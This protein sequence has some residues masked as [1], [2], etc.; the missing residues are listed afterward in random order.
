[1]SR[2]KEEWLKGLPNIGDIKAPRQGFSFRGMIGA[3][4]PI[5][6]TSGVF[7]YAILSIAYEMFYSRLGIDPAE[8]GL[9][10]AGIL[11][12]SVGFI[13][14]TMGILLTLIVVAI[15]LPSALGLMGDLIKRKSTWTS[16]RESFYARIAR[17]AW[18]QLYLLFC[19]IVIWLPIVFAQIPSVYASIVQN[20][21]P[22]SPVR[23]GPVIVL[24]I[25]A[26]PVTL[27]PL[28]TTQGESPYIAAL[29]KNRDLLYLGQNDGISVI[30][31]PVND[32]VIRIS[33][34]SALIQ[35]SNC[36]VERPQP[37]DRRCIL[38]RP[39]PKD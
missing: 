3:L 33:N 17:P 8:V 4:T 2:L 18:L 7:I 22:L 10:Y 20:G 13:L 14:V 32:Q 12:R 19:L 21:Y 37:Q 27:K 1:V 39:D 6:A 23:F 11:A 31:D 34:A 25:H 5:L 15:V 16:A 9:D 35:V 30:Y 38:P 28:T 26:A 24:S 29:Q 36:E